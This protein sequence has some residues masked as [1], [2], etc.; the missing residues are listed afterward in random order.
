MA[1]HSENE[2]EVGGNSRGNAA[3]LQSQ[4]QLPRDDVAAPPSAP[5]SP[6]ASGVRGRASV[7]NDGTKRSQRCSGTPRRVLVRF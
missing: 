5:S 3:S 1:R 7:S 4:N 6:L 2:L